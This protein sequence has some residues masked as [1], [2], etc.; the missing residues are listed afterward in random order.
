MRENNLLSNEQLRFRIVGL[1][2]CCFPK[3]YRRKPRDRRSGW[4]KLMHWEVR[5]D[6]GIIIR[7]RNGIPIVRV[8][9]IVSRL[10]VEGGRKRLELRFIRPDSVGAVPCRKKSR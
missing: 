2:S 10:I 5:L 3:I 7:V 9:M 1:E 8:I 6:G 4:F